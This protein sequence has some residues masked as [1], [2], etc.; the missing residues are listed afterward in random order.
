MDERVFLAQ[1]PTCLNERWNH[2]RARD[3]VFE[4]FVYCNYDAEIPHTEIRSANFPSCRKIFSNSGTK[5]DS[6]R[7]RDVFKYFG[8]KL[9]DTVRFAEELLVS[10]VRY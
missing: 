5:R 6:S 3:L 1:S 8:D 7:E 2:A 4:F 10:R 9:L